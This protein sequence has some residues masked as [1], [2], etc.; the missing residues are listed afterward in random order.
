MLTKLRAILLAPLLLAL[1]T[2]G[3]AA[4]QP[5][6]PNG[7]AVDRVTE[8]VRTIGAGDPNAARGFVQQAYGPAFLARD[9]FDVHVG[10][11]LQMHDR[12]RGMEIERIEEASPTR[13]V[14]LVRQSLTGQRVRLSV[15]VEPDAPHRIVN[16]GLR[17]VPSEAAAR[18]P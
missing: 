10:F 9:P 17:P 6:A 13:A 14:T 1:A 3:V 8:L 5:A 7:P 18:R 4:Q 12:T 11:L 2:P 16:I 15:E